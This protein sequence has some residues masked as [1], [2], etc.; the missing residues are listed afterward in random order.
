MSNDEN[1]LYKFSKDYII[2]IFIGLSIALILKFFVFELAEVKGASMNPT[3]EN[4][5]LLLVEKITKWTSNYNRYDIVTFDS[6]DKQAPI[7]IKRIIGL[8]KDHVVIKDNKIYV[9]NAEINESYL[10]KNTITTGDIDLEVPE[11]EFF[12]LG[13]NRTQSKDS[14]IIGTIKQS[15]IRGVVF[16]ILPQFIKFLKIN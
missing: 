1:K 10:P 9:N 6:D 15:Q 13:D 8:P 14:R 4:G 11:K 5:N 2:P 16:S 12:V 7:Y 3:Y